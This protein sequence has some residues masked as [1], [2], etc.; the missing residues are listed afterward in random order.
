MMADFFVPQILNSRDSFLYRG[1]TEKHVQCK[2]GRWSIIVDL[3][4]DRCA[5]LKVQ[6]GLYKTAKL[7]RKCFMYLSFLMVCSL[8]N[9]KKV[10]IDLREE[11][12]SKSLIFL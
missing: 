10:I 8:N 5:F 1:L 6:N 4:L 2:T 3:F 7:F 12:C 11:L 9:N